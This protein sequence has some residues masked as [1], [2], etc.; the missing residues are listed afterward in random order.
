MA[1]SAARLGLVA[2]DKL[3]QAILRKCV[4]HYLPNHQV[5]RSDV[6]GGRGNVQRKLKAYAALART[7][8][9]VVCVDLDSDEC[10]PSLLKSWEPHFSRAPALLLRIA[11]REVES[12]VLADRKRFAQ[13]IDAQSDDITNNPDSL[14]DPKRYLLELTRATAKP[15]LKND[16]LP[17]NFNKHPRI[18]PAYNLRMCEFVQKKWRPHV[19]AERS[20]SLARAVAAMTSIP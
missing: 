8:P 14:D 19:A 1:S 13:F 3:T 9:V 20:E 7:L 17:R 11:V 2:E 5:V 16:L 15:E 18:G 12:W 10:P 6:E 4:A